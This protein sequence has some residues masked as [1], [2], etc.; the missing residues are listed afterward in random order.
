MAFV[1]ARGER[2]ASKESNQEELESLEVESLESRQGPS[3]KGSRQGPAQIEAKVKQ[4][5]ALT[6]QIKECS[7]ELWKFA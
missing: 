5:E 4:K 6:N 3:I 1:L 2:G 7:G